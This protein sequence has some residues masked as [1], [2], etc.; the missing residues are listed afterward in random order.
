MVDF[1]SVKDR[2]TKILCLV[3]HLYENDMILIE[4]RKLMKSK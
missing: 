3:A 1:S 2:T 4:E